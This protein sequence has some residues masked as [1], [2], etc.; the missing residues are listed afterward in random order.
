MVLGLTVAVGAATVA[1][2][3]QAKP[4][5]NWGKVWK[6]EIRPKA[7]QRYYQKAAADARFEAKGWGYS[8]SESDARYAATGSSY[9]KS[10]SDARYA[11]QQKLYRGTYFAGG[12]GGASTLISGGGISFGVTF[13]AAPVA[14]YITFGSPVPAGCSGTAAAPN[15]EPGHLC[16]FETLVSNMG[17]NRGTLN[18]GGGLGS[19]PFGAGVFGFTAAAGQ[20]FML[21]TWA[22]RPVAVLA[23]SVAVKGG[24]FKAPGQG[25]A[26]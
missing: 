18:S 6:K 15:A 9:S 24:D 19:T 14:H 23:Q 22:A 7:D 26:H 20:G 1:A 8:K 25:L 3:A 5:H 4:D 12:N 16:V 10:E 2:P 11:P 21:G 17:A 13:S